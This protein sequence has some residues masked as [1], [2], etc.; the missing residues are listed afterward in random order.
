MLAAESFLD[1]CRVLET[2]ALCILGETQCPSG[3]RRLPSAHRAWPLPL[4]GRP[5]QESGLSFLLSHPE[6]L[7]SGLTAPVQMH[8]ALVS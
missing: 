6:G 2:V 5:S 8:L 4:P 1:I 3:L 7:S